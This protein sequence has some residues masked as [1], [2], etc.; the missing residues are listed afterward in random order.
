MTLPMFVFTRYTSART[1]ELAIFC[2][3]LYYLLAGLII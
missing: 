1:H 2:A 3:L